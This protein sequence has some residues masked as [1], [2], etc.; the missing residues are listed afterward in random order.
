MALL[1]PRFERIDLEFVVRDVKLPQGGVLAQAG[2]Q[3]LRSYVVESATC[4]TQ[5]AQGLRADQKIAQAGDG[6]SIQIVATQIQ[7][8]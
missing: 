6:W 7:I 3:R 1:R 8:L 4:E 2:S 5:R